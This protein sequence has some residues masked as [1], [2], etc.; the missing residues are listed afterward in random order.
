M[1]TRTMLQ[2]RDAPST[3]LHLL[4]CVHYK[5]IRHLLLNGVQVLLLLL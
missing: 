1:A 3:L 5:C 2:A 4:L